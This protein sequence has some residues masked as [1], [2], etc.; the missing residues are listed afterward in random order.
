M[1]VLIAPNSMKGTLTAFEFADIVEKGLNKA[2][3]FDVV[4]LPVADGGDGTAEVLSGTYRSHF[5]H[6]NVIDPLG[7]EIESGY[8]IG[9]DHTAIIEMASASGL[10]LLKKSEYSA[11]NST[12]FGTGQLIEHAI[13]SGAKTIILGVGGSATV[14]GGMGAL[15]ALGVK[16]FGSK[17]E[18]REGNGSNMGNVVFTD[19]L[20]ANGLLKDVK[21]FILTDV[22]NQLLGVDGAVPV[23]APQKGAII[24]E[25]KFLEKN[26]S[27][28]AGSLFQATGIDVSQI[29][30]GGAAGGIAASFHCLFGAEIVDGASFIL[31]KLNFR[32]LASESDVIITGEG[33]IDQTTFN[34]KVPGVILKIGMEINKPVFAICGEKK[35]VGSG[36]FESI[37][38]MVNSEISSQDTHDNPV[39][40]L[41]LIAEILGENII[42]KYG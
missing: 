17:G 34:G 13:K 41:D 10:K 11:I 20:A 38:S 26:L 31:E 2:G 4:K 32:E 37:L 40:Y 1:K 36:G 16:F 29:Q 12:S 7:R 18:I 9:K 6:C 15:M 19:Y 25:L 3:I 42:E 28:F 39:Y 8:F 21:L 30:G 27:L 14:D 5:I 24:R 33:R 23:F 22:K 35:L